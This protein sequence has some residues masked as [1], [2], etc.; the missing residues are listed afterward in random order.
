M[1]DPDTVRTGGCACGG[2]T[3]RAAGE[4][5]RVGLCHCMTCR[6]TTGSA[7]GAFVIYPADQVTVAGRRQGWSP[8]AATEQFFCPVCG[9]QV[10]DRSAP[11][12]IEL[13]LGAFD[14]PNLF[15]PTYEA[16]AKRREVWLRTDHLRR[17][18]EN[19]E[20]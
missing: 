9:S 7:F 10:F 20:G 4:P 1:R 18:E 12:E 19:R 15:I 6:K 14:E 2:L 13:M 16:W 17:F 8:T 3:F 5:K 11:D